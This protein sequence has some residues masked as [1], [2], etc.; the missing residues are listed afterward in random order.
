MT[1]L[2]KELEWV[3]AKQK[4]FRQIQAHSGMI[5]IKTY[6]IPCVNLTQQSRVSR[7]MTYSKPETYS[8][9]WYIQNLEILETV[10]YPQPKASTMSNIFDDAFCENS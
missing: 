9:P 2:D 10:A 8:E 1:P 5:R 6:S 3:N 7:T 4:P